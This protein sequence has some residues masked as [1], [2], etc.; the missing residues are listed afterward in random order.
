[1][2]GGPVNKNAPDNVH[3]LS[4]LCFIP[5]RRQDHEVPAMLQEITRQAILPGG[6]LGQVIHEGVPPREAQHAGSQPE[7][8]AVESEPE[9]DDM[10]STSSDDGAL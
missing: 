5:F 4:D 1:L 3:L 9:L 7:P 8:S 10:S 2:T 6:G